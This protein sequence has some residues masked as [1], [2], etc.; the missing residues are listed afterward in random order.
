[1]SL[2]QSLDRRVQPPL[3]ECGPAIAA[4]RRPGDALEAPLG[5]LD[6]GVDQLGLD[7]LDVRS[8]VDASLGV[9]DVRS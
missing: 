2:L 1:V 7:R 9:D 8:Q 4:M 3:R 6:V 5:L